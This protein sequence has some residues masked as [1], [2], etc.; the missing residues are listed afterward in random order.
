ML[1]EKSKIGLSTWGS[2]A[3]P[4]VCKKLDATALPTVELLNMSNPPM[5]LSELRGGDMVLLNTGSVLIGRQTAAT[6]VSSLFKRG[7]RKSS[8][9]SNPGRNPSMSGDPSGER[10]NDRSRSRSSNEFVELGGEGGNRD[11]ALSIACGLFSDGGLTSTSLPCLAA[12]SIPVP[13]LLVRLSPR[14]WITVVAVDVEEADDREVGFLEE[15]IVITFPF[16]KLAS[17]L[18]TWMEISA[19]FLSVALSAV[20]VPT[21]TSSV[22]SK[23]HWIPTVHFSG[24]T[25]LQEQEQV[26]PE[27]CASQL[28]GSSGDIVFF[29]V[30]FLRGRYL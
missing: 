22:V 29:F 12:G 13:L 8:K 17:P 26:P 4:G 3:E 24:T 14:W 18:P 20:E 7:S 2:I 9:Q 28:E 5:R 6:L 15:E 1:S 25:L 19:V 30:A 21:P 10:S 27:D 23:Q 16:L 11:G